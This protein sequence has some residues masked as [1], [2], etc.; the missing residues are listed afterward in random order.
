[1]IRGRLAPL[2]GEMLVC[3]LLGLLAWLL[4]GLLV[5]MAF[6]RMTRNERYDSPPWPAAP[7]DPEKASEAWLA[8]RDEQIPG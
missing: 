4:I 8:G 3:L 7:T 5:A 2:G 1:M 6:G